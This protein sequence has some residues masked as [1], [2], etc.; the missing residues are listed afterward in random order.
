MMYFL[1]LISCVLPQ[2]NPFAFQLVLLFLKEA[3]DPVG[4]AVY[5][6]LAYLCLLGNKELT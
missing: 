2:T 3:V 6:Y 1:N 5:I 4:N